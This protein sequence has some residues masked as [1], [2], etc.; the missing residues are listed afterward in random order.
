MNIVKSIPAFL[1][2]ILFAGFG[3]AYLLHLM[4]TPPMTGDMATFMELFDKSGYMTIVKILE[5]IGG[6]LVILPRTRAI[7]LCILAPI[8]VNILLFELCIAKAPG[9]GIAVCIGVALAIFL[10]KDKF[11]GLTS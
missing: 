5:V 1:L 7:G 2:A 10:E 6:L 3:I 8:A 4:P 11:K 9:I